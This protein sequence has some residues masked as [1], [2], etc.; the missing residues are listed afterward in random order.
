MCG[1]PSPFHIYEISASD[2]KF[3]LYNNK[4]FKDCIKRRLKVIGDTAWGRKS[5]KDII[6]DNCTIKWSLKG[7]EVEKFWTRVA[8]LYRKEKQNPGGINNSDTINFT[9]PYLKKIKNE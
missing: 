5:R 2:K 3:N 8:A 9:Q 7:E 4:A 1:S 6:F